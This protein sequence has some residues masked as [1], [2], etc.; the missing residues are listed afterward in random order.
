[1]APHFEAQPDQPVVVPRAR[2]SH[3]PL[4]GEEAKPLDGERTKPRG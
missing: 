2:W 1:M 4:D 3:A